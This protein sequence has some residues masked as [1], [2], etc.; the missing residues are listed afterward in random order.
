MESLSASPPLRR[1]SARARHQALQFHG[2]MMTEASSSKR[3]NSVPRVSTPWASDLLSSQFSGR[4]QSHPLSLGNHSLAATSN[5]QA[6]TSPAPSGRSRFSSEGGDS[7]DSLLVDDLRITPTARSARDPSR[8]RSTI[9]ENSYANFALAAPTMSHS[10]SMPGY[11]GLGNRTRGQSRPGSTESMNGR[12]AGT[13]DARPEADSWLWLE[14]VG[15]PQIE[16][17]LDKACRNRHPS[18]DF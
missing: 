11:L 9:P 7:L 16:Q 8:E 12:T 5:S 10:H 3:L 15:K 4:S 13:D 18:F 1:E 14:E 2:S 6:S 17:K